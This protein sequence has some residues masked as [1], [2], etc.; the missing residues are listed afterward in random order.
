MKCTACGNKCFDDIYPQVVFQDEKKCIC[1][2]CS[3]DFEQ[4]DGVVQFR[5]DLVE[6]GYVEPVFQIKGHFRFR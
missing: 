6:Q 3:L 5:K 4:I 1:E 2:E